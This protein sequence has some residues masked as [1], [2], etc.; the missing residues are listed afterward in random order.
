M[1]YQLQYYDLVLAGII[2]A[3]G[4]GG[5]VGA[6]TWIRMPFAIAGLGAV[7]IGIMGHAMF[8]NGPIDD[9]DDLAEEVEEGQVSSERLPLVE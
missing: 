3:I 1:A 7:S 5:L 9:L 2:A 4:L 6:V 8:V